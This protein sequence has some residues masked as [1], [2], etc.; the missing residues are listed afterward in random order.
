VIVNPLTPLSLAPDHFAALP[1]DLRWLTDRKPLDAFLSDMA[2]VST[3][4]AKETATETVRKSMRL[5][6]RTLKAKI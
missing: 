4:S 5:F 1:D 2:S 6:A 3:I